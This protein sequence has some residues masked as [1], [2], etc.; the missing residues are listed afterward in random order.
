MKDMLFD[1]SVAIFGV[2]FLVFAVLCFPPI[3]MFLVM[4]E[5]V[6]GYKVLAVVHGLLTAV[7]FI[8]AVSD[9]SL[10]TDNGPF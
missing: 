6:E 7:W 8:G 2:L 1:I 10:S 9:F 5:W 3:G 4:L